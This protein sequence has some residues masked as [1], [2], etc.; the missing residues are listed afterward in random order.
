MPL[1]PRAKT[2]EMAKTDTVEAARFASTISD[3]WYRCQALAMVAWHT[4]AKPTFRRLAKEALKAAKKLPNPNR[5][6]A[7]SAWIIRAIAR[8]GNGEL[9]ELVQECLKDILK[10]ENPVRRAD[11]LFLLYEAVFSIETLRA[12][13][14]ESLWTSIAEMKS[15]KKGRLLS[16]LALV[17]TGTNVERAVEIA[18]AI[19]KTPL[20]EKTLVQIE[21]KE[22]LGPH[23]F[24]PHYTKSVEAHPVR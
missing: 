3:D 24:F 10:E 18:R 8:R 6:V 1:D 17:V 5:R 4:S 14:F 9:E 12:T 16:D 7:C 13:V 21:N 20:R 2:W 11:A 19:D 23:E 22:W 15:W